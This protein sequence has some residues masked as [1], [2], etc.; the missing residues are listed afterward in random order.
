MGSITQAD[1]INNLNDGLVWGLLPILLA[2]LS[3]SIDR[4]GVI[5]GI[6]PAIWGIGQLATGK[7]CDHLSKKKML[8][9]GMLLQ[10]ITLVLMAWTVSYLQFILLSFALGLGTAIV[11][12]T[13]LAAVADHTHPQQRAL[14]IGIFRLWR[15]LGYAIG[16]LLTGILTDWFGIYT[17][18][19]V[20]GFL[21]LTSAW[22]I[23]VRMV[24][25]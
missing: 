19:L 20:I 2:D 1:L 3:F 13:F 23:Q 17:A 18:V 12:P 15:D 8:F 24:D 4:I 22:V 11:Y 5:T 6:Y 21:T 10:G 7:M 25:K 14:S 16:A 9:W